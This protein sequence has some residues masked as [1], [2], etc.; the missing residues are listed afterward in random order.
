MYKIELKTLEMQAIRDYRC[1]LL[2]QKLKNF[3]IK[4]KDLHLFK[5]TKF[6]LRSTDNGIRLLD[7]GT[8]KTSSY[9]KAKE[10]LQHLYL[11]RKMKLLIAYF[12]A[13]SKL[14]NKNIYA[15]SL[16]LDALF[17]TYLTDEFITNSH[18]FFKLYPRRELLKFKLRA[19]ILE[20]KIPEAI[21]LLEKYKSQK[22]DPGQFI[23][24]ARAELAL[25]FK[26]DEQIK[27]ICRELESRKTYNNKS[28]F[29]LAVLKSYLLDYESAN[30]IFHSLTSDPF[31]KEI[32][33]KQL[34]DNYIAVGHYNEALKIL[35]PL[36]KK[37]PDQ[38]WNNSSIVKCLNELKK[39]DDAIIF[40]KSKLRRGRHLVRLRLLLF[41]CYRLKNKSEVVVRYLAI[42]R[43][44]YQYS[45]Y[46]LVRTILLH[47]LS[48][49]LGEAH[50]LLE[51]K[52]GAIDPI[53][54]SKI[55]LTLYQF[56]KKFLH[57]AQELQKLK[58]QNTVP[59]FSNIS[60]LLKLYIAEQF[61]N[62]Y[63]ESLSNEEEFETVY[64]IKKLLEKS[65]QHRIVN[66]K[67]EFNPNS[68]MMILASLATGG[69][70]R[71]LVNTAIQFVKHKLD[72]K[73]FLIVAKLSN[74]SHGDFYLPH[75]NAAQISCRP[76][77]QE[78]ASFKSIDQLPELA[79]FKKYEP[80]LSYS[81]IT[82]LALCMEKHKPEVVHVRGGMAVDAGIAA[83]LIGIPHVLVHF[84]SMTRKWQSDG[85]SS[86]AMKDQLSKQMFRFLSQYPHISF[87]CNS[88][89][90]I[91]DWAD[92]LELPVSRFHLIRNGFE[93]ELMGEVTEDK[94]EYLRNQLGIEKD[95]FVLGAVYRFHRV[96]NPLMFIRIASEFKKANPFKKFK[97][98]LV[99]DGELKDEIIDLA[100]TLDLM[101]HLIM[102]GKILKDIGLYYSLMNVYLMTSNT[103]S[104]PNVVI[105]A[106]Y[107]GVPV[108]AKNVGGTR[109]AM[110]VGKT[111]WLVEES[112]GVEGFL[113][114]LL[115]IAEL[116]DQE[117]LNI[118]QLAR[119]F[120]MEKF[121]VHQMLESTYKAYGLKN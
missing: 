9:F 12:N 82:N 95:D 84:G 83:L 2:K 17:I 111:G 62:E 76:F 26:N 99:G 47:I 77:W 28:L 67:K 57:A 121:S 48:G 49:Y 55:L 3:Y 71:Q 8:L 46:N 34:I 31:F 108:L 19:L 120:V 27:L 61:L 114:P 25:E 54:Y 81:H 40:L 43:N 70:E 90:A 1:Y 69:S 13:H 68:V 56:Q 52:K 80:L 33:P 65:T 119:S 97:I 50:L 66:S 20:L 115:R 37:R 113:K 116:G 24:Q 74:D 94:V 53:S 23:I 93:P 29:T 39:T 18:A 64:I 79:I 101:S 51:A 75:L 6:K 88:E 85:T 22:I 78:K 100:R 38:F 110:D 72:L 14:L 102:P 4:K 106:Q 109:E 41:N 60:G 7:N 103:E 21:T 98:L 11:Q 30:S 10:I 92:F 16:Y 96:K 104:L 86:F 45:K 42:L 36:N 35:Y 32:A 5:T 89:S 63:P 112:E 105:E 118:A 107:F 44:N 15:I 59:Q 117:L 91:G 58:L 73:P 87:A